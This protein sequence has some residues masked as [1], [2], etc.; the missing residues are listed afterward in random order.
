MSNLNRCDEELNRLNNEIGLKLRE[1]QNFQHYAERVMS[2]LQEEEKKWSD[3][4]SSEN[5]ELAKLS[6][7]KSQLV[8]N[9]QS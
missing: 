7:T 8:A 6:S 4:I 9:F 5:R 3:R 1:I 2:K